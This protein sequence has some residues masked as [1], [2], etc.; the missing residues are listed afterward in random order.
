MKPMKWLL[1]LFGAL[2]LATTLGPASAAGARH[3]SSFGLASVTGSI[4][5]ID[6]AGN[7]VTIK[8]AQGL[9]IKL[10]VGA[11]TVIDRNGTRSTMAGLTL[12]DS[13]TAQYKASTLTLR[14]VTASGPVVST[15]VG[16]ASGVSVAGATVAI[17]GKTF[18]TNASTK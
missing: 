17:G 16:P 4:Q 9:S 18:Q 12:N 13:V 10:S 3:S 8:T 6:L 1:A 14:S 5:T 7:Y 15:V 2:M 11:H